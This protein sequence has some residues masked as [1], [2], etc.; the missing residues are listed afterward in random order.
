MTQF[1]SYIMLVIYTV[2]STFSA[3]YGIYRQA[4]PEVRLTVAMMSDTHID[5]K[6]LLVQNNFRM[7]MRNLKKVKNLDA[8]LFNGDLT[9]YGDEKS[10][11]LFYDI[12][13]K[14]CPPEKVIVSYGNHDIG[15]TSDLGMTSEEAR[16]QC[17]KYLNDFKGTS[18]DRI[19]YSTEVN[20]Y[21]FITLCDEGEHWD[22]CTITNKQLDF[23]DR[24][25]AEGTEGGKPVFVTCHWPMDG[26]NGEDTVSFHQ[27]G[28]Y[29]DEND[30]DGCQD[31][32]MAVL[33][34]YDNVFFISGHM[35]K[36][37]DGKYNEN[38]LGFSWAETDENGVTYV[39]LPTYGLVNIYG[40]FWW[41][42]GSVLEVYDDHVTFKG[43]SY[44]LG[45]EVRSSTKSFDLVG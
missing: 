40:V 34:K 41:G 8:V 44:R 32:I 4:E 28:T 10:L 31:K 19:Y 12:V 14:Y 15:H 45:L 39:S 43:I 22:E 5:A 33:E 1:L 37:L 29:A 23:L 25:L 30:V 21:K 6:E 35:H 27:D 36:G 20:G 3:Q 42:T 16:A 38:K 17:L 18:Y 7:G 2:I 11:K 26:K 9:N 24:E 13:G